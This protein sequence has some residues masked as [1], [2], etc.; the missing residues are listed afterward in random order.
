MKKKSNRKYNK[1]RFK[2]KQIKEEIANDV[3]IIEPAGKLIID[4]EIPE[5]VKETKEGIIKLED[6]YCSMYKD[7]EYS[8]DD[9]EGEEDSCWDYEPISNDKKS[10]ENRVK[11]KKK[12]NAIRG[13][14]FPCQQ[15]DITFQVRTQAVGCGN[16]KLFCFLIIIIQLFLICLTASCQK[17]ILTTSVVMK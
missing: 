1:K 11:V 10:T 12:R 2:A 6:N 16:Y 3:E 17:L 14:P 7:D 8:D 13:P 5:E 4:E 15:C 9:S